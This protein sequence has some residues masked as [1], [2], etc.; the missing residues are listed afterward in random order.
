MNRIKFLS[1]FALTA[2]FGLALAFTF[3]CSD[4]KDEG[5]TGTGACKH[6]G[7]FQN[8]SIEICESLSLASAGITVDQYKKECESDATYNG[9]TFLGSCPGGY[10][11][12]CK[13]DEDDFDIT[14][15]LYDEALKDVDCNTF[16]RYYDN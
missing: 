14:Y 8:S 13:N 12:T 3:S 16:F 15:H 9:S 5:G 11:K 6:T 1:K 7:K 2:A 10:V 4:D